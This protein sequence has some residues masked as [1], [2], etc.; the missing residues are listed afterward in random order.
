MNPGAVPGV[1]PGLALS[2]FAAVVLV[3]ALFLWP[4]RGLLA[5]VMLRWRRSARTQREDVL[6]HLLN[7]EYAGYRATLESIAGAVE[8][9]Q[10][11][12]AELLAELGESGLADSDAT[13]PLL[14][15]AGRSDATR[16][17]RTHRLWEQYFA[18]RTGVEPTDW[19]RRA[20]R[21]EHT[22]TR[23]ETERLAA[24]LGNPVYDPHGDP[25]P[26]SSGEFPSLGG[27]PL[28]ALAPGQ[29]GRI[30]HLEDE[31][32]EVFRTLQRE[33]LSPYMVLQRLESPRG[34]VRI[35]LEGREVVLDPVAAG[36]VTVVTP[37][38]AAV[39]TSPPLTLNRIGVGESAVVTDI[40]RSCQ[41]VQRRRMLDLG[42][43]PGTL[44][45]AEMASASGDPVA[46]SIRGAL[47]ALRDEQAS[48]IHVRRPD[49]SEGSGA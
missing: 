22:L 10:D 7:C 31:P 11:R 33:G 40:S 49:A 39:P 34:E 17:L 37:A 19:H 46:Y 1:D 26:T 27:V 23:E 9:S 41:G 13:G 18:D 38:P 35:R 24:S 12:A 25:I 8:I 28:R 29:V 14:T 2:V 16:I 5:Q 4:G 48:W 6:K 43:V 45:T 42:V 36:N 20:E 47:I 3:L 32:P 15:E 21:L 44:I 30:V